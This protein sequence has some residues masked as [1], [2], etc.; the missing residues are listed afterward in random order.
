M[1][2]DNPLLLDKHI[3]ERAEAL[4][5]AL[6]ADGMK[7]MG[8]EMDGCMCS[9]VMPITPSMK[10]AGTALTVETDD[11]DNFPIHVATYAG[12]E[13]YVMVIDG[14]NCSYRPYFGELIASAAKAVG[15]GEWY[16]TDWCAT[17][18]AA[19]SL[20]FRSLQEAFYSGVL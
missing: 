12:G 8:I 7:G 6:L 19:V 3:V 2:K 13:G 17:G 4:G 10:M 11:G 14:K 18:T 5:S 16:V 15:L 20:D 9:D 1:M